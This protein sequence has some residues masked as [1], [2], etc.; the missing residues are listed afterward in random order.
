MEDIRKLLTT[1]AYNILGSY[2]DA[3][4]IVQDAYLKFC[5]I[6]DKHI[7][8]K[9]AYLIRIVINLSI[10][11]KKRQKKMEKQYHGEWLPEPVAT[12]ESDSSIV[13]KEI[14]SYSLMVLLEK[15]NAK[16]RAVFILKEAFEY[17]HKEIAE[18][19]QTTEENCRKIYSRAKHELKAP[20]IVDSTFISKDYLDKYMEVIYNADTK[21]LE[22]LLQKDI[23]VISDG[24]GKVSASL[25]PVY[26]K[27]L[28]IKFLIG[29]YQKF[30]DTSETSIEKTS[31]NHH[32]A[33]LYYKNQKLS[34]CQIFEF[35]NK[36]ISRI[37]FIRNPDKLLSLTQSPL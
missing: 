12:E 4:D 33:L 20:N 28:T 11:L 34:V 37:Y 6:D 26:G 2:E 16:Q 15:L 8:N 25:H 14:L 7:E 30:Y 1:Y 19:L 23:S 22:N 18:L 24:G 36:N 13:R 21:Q 5:N 27:S 35:E 31:V 3:K 10:N 9:K 17:G 32:P 29:I